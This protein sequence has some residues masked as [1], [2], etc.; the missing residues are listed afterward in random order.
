[1]NKTKDC[2]TIH[3]WL[4][5]IDVIEVAMPFKFINLDVNLNVFNMMTGI[6]E[7]KTLTKHISCKYKE[8][9]MAENI[10]QIKIEI[11]I[12]LDVSAKMQENIT[13]L[14]KIKYL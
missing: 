12:N 11:K 14:K 5:L 3:L 2:I 4:I 7:S 8:S 1:M 9:L 13:Y 10:I 6:N